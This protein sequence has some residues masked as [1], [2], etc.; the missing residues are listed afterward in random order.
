METVKI[1]PKFQVVIPRSIRES[2]H[3]QPGQKMQVVEFGDRIEFV[4]LR[5][6]G[7]LRGFARGINTTIDREQDR[8]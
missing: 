3:L 2:M 4:P 8:V 5:T 6:L 7:D 1:S